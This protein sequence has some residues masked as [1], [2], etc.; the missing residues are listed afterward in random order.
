MTEYFLMY[1]L[2]WGCSPWLAGLAQTLFLL[3]LFLGEDTVGLRLLVGTQLS[4]VALAVLLCCTQVQLEMSL[5][6]KRGGMSLGKASFQVKLLT[7]K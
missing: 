5:I 3:Q 6:R 1:L 2:C 4:Q 7:D